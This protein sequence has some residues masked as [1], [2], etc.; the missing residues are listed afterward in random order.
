MMLGTTSWRWILVFCMFA[1]LCNG[2]Q[3]TSSAQTIADVLQN[4]SNYD[5]LVAALDTAGLLADLSGSGPFTLF[6]PSNS[7]LAM[8]PDGYLKTLTTDPG[9]IIHLQNLLAFHVDI[10]AP[11]EA[12]DLTDGRELLMANEE[13]LTVSNSGGVISL[14]NNDGASATVLVPDEAVVSNGVLHQLDQAL[15]PKFVF[16]NVYNETGVFFQNLL[17]TAGLVD[18]V[19]SGEFTIILPSNEAFVGVPSDVFADVDELTKILQYHM[20]DQVLPPQQLQN[21][22]YK[23]VNG[24]SLVVSVSDDGKSVTFDGIPVQGV[25]LASNGL[26]YAIDAVLF[27]GQD[28]PTFAPQPTTAPVSMAPTVAGQPNAE[29][30]PSIVPTATS[31]SDPN[32]ADVIEAAD[33]LKSMALALQVSSLLDQVR[34]IESATI[35]APIDEAFLQVNQDLMSALFEPEWVAHLQ[36]LLALHAVSPDVLYAANIS[37]GASVTTLSG[38]AISFVVGDEGSV[39]VNGP[40]GTGGV[41]I[42][43]DVPAS[44]G[45]LHKLDTLLL[46]S[47]VDQDLL[48]IGAQIDEIATFM[49]LIT[50]TGLD[51]SVATGLFTLLAP[52]EDAFSKLMQGGNQTL[53]DSANVEELTKRLQY[54]MIPRLIPTQLLTNSTIATLEGSNILA[55]VVP[56]Q[57]VKFNDASALFVDIPANNGLIYIID[58]VMEIQDYT[59]S[60]TI[61]SPAA[62]STLT[63]SEAPALTA[64]SLPVSP[65]PSG[66][67]TNNDTSGCAYLMSEIVFIL[68]AFISLAIIF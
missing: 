54:H 19:M 35:F 14:G 28:V 44:N 6:A 26:I 13:Y 56:G 21:G 38:E 9:Y 10:E 39:F 5:S 8:V 12:A 20:I 47:W 65:T 51:Q 60:P 63:P 46:P 15:L 16:T 1:R 61:A 36:S 22:Q 27:P 34:S 23:T 43:A 3:P 66:P 67:V 55:S 48:A 31:M 40:D 64:P 30:A 32:L 11:L 68:C 58:K 18:F 53:T 4:D 45:V 49:G 59:D 7:A 42:E 24:E 17:A 25:N 37:D 57:Q 50:S 29:Q 62:G 2:Q 33:D 41:V 52:S